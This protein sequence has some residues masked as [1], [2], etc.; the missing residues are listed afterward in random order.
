MA[1]PPD[2]DGVRH[3]VEA[4]GVE[5]KL[6]PTEFRLLAALAA[7]PGE[8]IEHDE[9]CHLVWGGRRPGRKEA[10]LYVSYVRRKLI[11]AANIDPFETVWGV[12][13]RYLPRVREPVED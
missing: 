1:E 9:L 3:R 5:V 11:Q 2:V 7:R 13:Y 12:G 6:T 10:K 8:V 4:G